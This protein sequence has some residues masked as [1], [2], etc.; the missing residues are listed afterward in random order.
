MTVSENEICIRNVYDTL[1]RGLAR[2]VEVSL[3]HCSVIYLGRLLFIT[4][5]YAWLYAI[6]TI[7]PR[8]VWS[9]NDIRES[10]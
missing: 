10:M 2:Y 7:G 1:D 9:N 6:C 4:R 5:N 3:D 8:R